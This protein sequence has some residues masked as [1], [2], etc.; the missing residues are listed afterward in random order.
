MLCDFKSLV[1]KLLAIHIFSQCLGS[2]LSALCPAKIWSNA[3]YASQTYG[4][5]LCPPNSQNNHSLPRKI[6]EQC[7]I[8]SAKLWS[9]TDFAPQ[10]N[11]DIVSG[12][13]IISNFNF[14]NFLKIFFSNYLQN[15]YLYIN[16]HFAKTRCL[17]N[18]VPNKAQFRFFKY[19]FCVLIQAFQKVIAS[20]TFL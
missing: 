1:A 11:E 17:P 19:L 4:G 3:N 9:N 6:M 12:A 5:K 8:C 15:R 13:N 18:K 7:R 20:C 10:N 2:V 14:L 16:V